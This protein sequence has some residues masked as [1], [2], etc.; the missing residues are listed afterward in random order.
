MSNV[1]A[2]ISNEIQSSTDK[3]KKGKNLDIVILTFELFSSL[4]LKDH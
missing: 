1:K 2:Q 4:K 3:I